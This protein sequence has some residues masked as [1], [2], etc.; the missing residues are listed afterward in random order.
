M[1]V[2]INQKKIGKMRI[3][4]KIGEKHQPKG[5]LKQ[6]F[7]KNK[8]SKIL[9]EAKKAHILNAHIFHTQ[10]AYELGGNVHHYQTE[11][12][13]SKLIVCL[14]LIDEREKLEK[15]FL[16]QKELLKNR[17]VTFKEIEYWTHQ[18]G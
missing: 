16:S 12:T 7:A 14:E 18:I 1:D 3:Y 6:L 5:F 13:N 15:F 11:G 10:A 4:L 8:Y 9:D 17:T 2:K